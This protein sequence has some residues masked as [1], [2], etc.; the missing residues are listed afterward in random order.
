MVSS[1]FRLGIPDVTLVTEPRIKECPSQKQHGK[2]K[3]CMAPNP[4]KA[5]KKIETMIKSG[6][7]A[8]TSTTKVAEKP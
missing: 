7:V 2:C 5:K 6:D 1:T 3:E 4:L 8:K